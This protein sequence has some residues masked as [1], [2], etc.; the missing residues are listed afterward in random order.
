MLT[1]LEALRVGVIGDDGAPVEKFHFQAHT[2]TVKAAH[3]RCHRFVARFPEGFRNFVAS[4]PAPVA[5]GWSGFRAVL[6][7]AATR[8][9]CPAQTHL[10]RLPFSFACPKDASRS[11]EQA[12][13]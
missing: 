4:M 6:A 11:Q 7:P 10:R 8:D 12:S 5:S 2:S 3:S 13:E 1:L 9:L